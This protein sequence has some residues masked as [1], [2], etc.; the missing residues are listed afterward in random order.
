M[1]VRTRVPAV[2][3][4][5]RAACA[6]ACA[7]PSVLGIA[8][9]GAPIPSR[10]SPAS[11]AARP[12]PTRSR[13]SPAPSAP[14]D[15]AAAGVGARARTPDE[16]VHE[17]HRREFFFRAS[18][19]Q[20]KKSE[21]DSAAILPRVTQFCRHSAH[22]LTRFCCGST[23]F[24]H[25]SATTNI[26]PSPPPFCRSSATV[27]PLFRPRWGVR[28]P[29]PA[30]QP[31]QGREGVVELLEQLKDGQ[32]RQDHPSPESTN[33]K[34]KAGRGIVE[35][36]YRRIV[37]LRIACVSRTRLQLLQSLDATCTRDT[38]ALCTV[39][40]RGQAGGAAVPRQSTQSA[41]PRW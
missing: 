11:H 41:P 22:A 29:L 32:R 12:V 2:A 16:V 39:S 8:G 3:A 27:L 36:A 19:R 6:C 4:A 17:R 33:K 14:V 15:K 26:R 35:L 21:G 1:P 37:E 28:A 5:A 40:L 30:S 7:G 25:G 31:G 24:C 18:A 9:P 13:R 38:Y 10:P 23:G 34:E 20:Q